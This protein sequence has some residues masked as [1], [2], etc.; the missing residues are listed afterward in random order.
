M[1]ISGL[2]WRKNALNAGK[3]PPGLLAIRNG[4]L[5]F[6]TATAVEFD[7]PVSTVT[8]SLTVWG[9]LA[10]T[11]DSRRYVFLT[12]VGQLAPPFSKTQQQAISAATRAHSLRT[13][14]EWPAIL[15]AAGAAVTAPKR[16]YRP[17]LLGGIM[18]LLAAAAA[19]LIVINGGI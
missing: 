1:D 2:Y 6:T 9:A 11:V 13:L 7:V 3:C 8:G 14:P 15:T 18:V 10:L 16:N 12:T 19:T 4:R 17:W 5:S